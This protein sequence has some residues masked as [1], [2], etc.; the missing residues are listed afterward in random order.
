MVEEKMEDLI[1][2][3]RS[4]QWKWEYAYRMHA[5]GTNRRNQKCSESNI[6]QRT[7]LCRDGIEI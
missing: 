5:N 6:L 2:F 3:V 4:K 1:Q 7:V